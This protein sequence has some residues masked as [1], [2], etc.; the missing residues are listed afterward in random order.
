MAEIRTTRILLAF[1][2]VNWFTGNATTARRIQSVLQR[3]ASCHVTLRGYHELPETNLELGEFV[4]ASRFDLIVIIHATKGARFLEGD[5]ALPPV[6]VVL[7]GTDVNIDARQ[8]PE[9]KACMLR[10]L[11]RASHVVAFSPTMI[12]PLPELGA[13]TRVAVI[14]QGI[15]FD[16]ASVDRLQ[17]LSNLQRLR[18]KHSIPDECPVFVLVAGIR[19][20]KDVLFLAPAFQ[21]MY[22]PSSP[23]PVLLIIGPVLDDAYSAEVRAAVDASSAV[24]LEGPIDRPE[25]LTIM[26]AS[27]GVINSSLSEG[28]SSVLLEAIGL[29]LRVYAR[30]IPG[31]RGLLSCLGADHASLMS[32]YSTP[33]DFVAVLKASSSSTLERSEPRPISLDSVCAEEAG[34]LDV[35]R[36]TSP[37][38]C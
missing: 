11:E 24:R 7:G 36:I 32:F 14:P 17:G 27:D 8:S 20:V 28:Q 30:D 10:R 22:S 19:P 18:S 13:V 33:D 37:P 21:S 3:V 1:P 12:E 15:D 2:L 34:W 38:H 31:N 26:A 29:G 4:K 9:A 16:P 6:V 35:L 23:H 5:I 25:L